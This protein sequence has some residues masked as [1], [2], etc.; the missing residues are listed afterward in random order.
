MF[1]TDQAARFVPGGKEYQALPRPKIGRS[2]DSVVALWLS[3]LAAPIELDQTSC[4]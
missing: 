1:L 4:K 2:A 3:F